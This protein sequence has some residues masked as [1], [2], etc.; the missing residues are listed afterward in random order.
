MSRSFLPY[1]TRSLL[2]LNAKPNEIS[3]S[4]SI[5]K[6]RR[7]DSDS[8]ENSNVVVEKMEE[9]KVVCIGINRPSK[10]NCVNKTTADQ[11]Y[12]AFSEFENDENL[13]CAVLHG[14]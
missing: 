6:I 11:L 1:L 13:N 4:F 2:R 10:R 14:K 3:R 7:N 5:S 9:F 8:K 12:E